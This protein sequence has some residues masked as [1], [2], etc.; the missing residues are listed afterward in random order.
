MHTGELMNLVCVDSVCT[1]RGLICPV[2]RMNN[3]ESHQILP[4]KVFLEEIKQLFMKNENNDDSLNNLSDYLR[5]LQ[6]SRKELINILK[7]AAEEIAREFKT[8]EENIQA[9]Y[10]AI[11]RNILAQVTYSLISVKHFDKAAHLRL[12]SQ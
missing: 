5:S 2:C 1:K 4:L 6:N 9:N 10:I 8:I 7:I 11:R 3:H 12:E